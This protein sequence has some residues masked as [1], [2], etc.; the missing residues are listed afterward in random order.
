MKWWAPRK[1]T[2]TVSISLY[3]WDMR[4]AEAPW[5]PAVHPGLTVHNAAAFRTPSGVASGLKISNC[6]GVS[7]GQPW[8]IVSEPLFFPI[9]LQGLDGETYIN[10]IRY[11]EIARCGLGIFPL[12]FF[13]F[14]H[15]HLFQVRGNQG[16]HDHNNNKRWIHGRSNLSP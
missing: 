11:R 13:S 7:L 10:T 3:K 15:T 9:D 6:G 14:L 4:T 2:W 16:L 12:F 8:N 1:S 5:M